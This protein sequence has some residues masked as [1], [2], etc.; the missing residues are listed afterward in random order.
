MPEVNLAS[1]QEQVDTRGGTFYP[2]LDQL[3][4]GE[5]SKSLCVCVTKVLPPRMACRLWSGLTSC[6]A[7]PIDPKNRYLW[8]SGTTRDGVGVP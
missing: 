1:H 2:P 7:S 3:G 8:P 4:T 5:V 6:L